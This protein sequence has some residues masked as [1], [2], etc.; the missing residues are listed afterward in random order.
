[1][2]RVLDVYLHQ[3]LVGHLIQDNSGDI[4]F[5]YTEAWLENP[6]AVVLSKSL[7]L[8]KTPFTRK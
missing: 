1:M 4:V 3:H 2:P 8:Q 6:H 5:S 7:P